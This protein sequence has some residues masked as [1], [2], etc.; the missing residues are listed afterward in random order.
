MYD[1]SIQRALRRHKIRPITLPAPLRDRLV[2]NF[3][4]AAPVSHIITGTAGD[5]KTY[6]CR[7]VWIELGGSSD[8][9]NQGDKVQQLSLTNGRTLVVV[10][11]LSEL[12]DDESGAL[13]S[14]LAT[15][16][17]HRACRTGDA[18]NAA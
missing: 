5:G 4:G 16:S 14:R 7:E 11:D 8:A 18:P 12:R 17:Y 3:R 9:W 13:I 6:H 15:D 2:T 10:K 1:E